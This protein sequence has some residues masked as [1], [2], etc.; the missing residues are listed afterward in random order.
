ME[1]K[2]EIG[3]KHQRKKQKC[4]F[5]ICLDFTLYAPRE[6]CTLC[7]KKCSG[8]HQVTKFLRQRPEDSSMKD[9]KQF[10]HFLQHHF[11]P[12]VYGINIFYDSKIFSDA[13]K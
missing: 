5:I 8:L 10:N 13:D 2:Y 3:F 7:R 6:I 12:S 1:N 11:L 9:I 4:Y